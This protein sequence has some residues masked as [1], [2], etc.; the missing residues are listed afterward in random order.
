MNAGKHIS[1]QSLAVGIL[2][3]ILMTNSCSK[4]P[5]DQSRPFDVFGRIV[6]RPLLTIDSAAEF[7]VYS[8]GRAVTD[9]EIIVKQDTIPLSDAGAGYYTR[10]M[11]L[12]IG[13]TVSYSIRSEKG[14]LN[15]SVIIPDTASIIFPRY[16]DSLAIG[17]EF[18]AIWHLTPRADGFFAYLENQRGYV[19]AVTETYYDTTATLPAEN[20]INIG[21]DRFW[22]ETL[23]GAF[24]SAI[25]PGNKIMPRGVVGAAGNSRDVYLYL[26]N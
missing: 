16:F 24:S 21:H 13:D 12:Q 2:M 17:V 15:G 9:A 25:T 23:S 6:F 5:T 18:T 20:S 11:Q 19:G 8:Y 26:S 3:L 22:V 14:S 10:P 4:K 7:Y 1:R